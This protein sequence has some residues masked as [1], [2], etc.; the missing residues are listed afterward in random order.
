MFIKQFFHL[1]SV[2]HWPGKPGID[3]TSV[4]T[5]KMVLDTPLLNTQH[6]KVSKNGELEESM[7]KSSVFSH[8]LV[9]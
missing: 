1:T 6:C 8:T 9:K 2:R 7:E 4:H 5:K 3:T